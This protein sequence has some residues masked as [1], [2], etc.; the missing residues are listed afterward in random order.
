METDELNDKMDVFYVVQGA[1]E[2][3][4]VENFIHRA[5]KGSQPES[6][7]TDSHMPMEEQYTEEDEEI[8]QGEHQ[9]T[10]RASQ[11]QSLNQLQPL[12]EGLK[13]V[14]R[15]SSVSDASSLRVAEIDLETNILKLDLTK[16]KPVEEENTQITHESLIRVAS[17]DES[18]D[19]GA[20]TAIAA[21]SK[22]DK[23]TIMRKNSSMSAIKS[24]RS[25]IQ[26]SALDVNEPSP[27]AKTRAVKISFLQ[28]NSQFKP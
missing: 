19:S 23:P 15:S 6:M 10:N 18:P 16:V 14:V 24:V 22:R 3:T 17:L 4:M 13:S 2:F 27:K 7:K 1:V 26:G 11:I 20:R 25:S 28:K 12:S 9:L 21:K 5:R 8:E